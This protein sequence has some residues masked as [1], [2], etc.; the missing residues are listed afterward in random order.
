V[1][2]LLTQPVVNQRKA[3]PLILRNYLITALKTKT[4][5]GRALDLSL[6][7]NMERLRQALELQTGPWSFSAEQREAFIV[8]SRV[9]FLAI[10][11][12]SLQGI[13]RLPPVQPWQSHHDGNQEG[14]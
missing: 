12:L 8:S 11:L 14:R 5:L 2:R 13:L 4:W 1:K 10:P 9:H 6:E 7:A 3:A